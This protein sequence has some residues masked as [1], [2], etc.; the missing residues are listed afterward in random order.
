MKCWLCVVI[1]SSLFIVFFINTASIIIITMISWQHLIRLSK[2]V[3]LNATVATE[4]VQAPLSAVCNEWDGPSWP[5][6]WGFI[7]W[8]SF[9]LSSEGW[10]LQKMDKPPDSIKATMA[11]FPHLETGLKQTCK[12]CSSLLCGARAAE[13]SSSIQPQG[14]NQFC[15]NTHMMQLSSA[16]L[17]A[18]RLATKS[19]GFDLRSSQ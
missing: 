2:S 8:P 11:G 18:K 5:D 1:I 6:H 17:I 10:V 14:L 13:N 4:I 19:H 7:F 3:T 15:M 9:P 12:L 16:K